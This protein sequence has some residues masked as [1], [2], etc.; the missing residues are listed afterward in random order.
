[1]AG[2]RGASGPRRGTPVYDLA[3]RAAICR[4]GAVGITRQNMALQGILKRMFRDAQRGPAAATDSSHRDGLIV[5]VEPRHVT[6][7]KTGGHSKVW[8]SGIEELGLQLSRYE[9]PTGIVGVLH[10]ACRTA[11]LRS[12]SL[13]SAVPHYVSLA[14]SP[15]AAKA[16]CTRLADLLGTP[17][18]MTELDEAESE[19][20]SQVSEA[21]ASDP[22]TQAYV[23]ELERRVMTDYRART[24]REPRMWV[25]R[26]VDGAGPLEA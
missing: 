13:W 2:M 15:R 6:T 14:P 21:V 3:R 25:V 8:F 24:G 23:E 7:I 1:M 22:D 4:Y 19:Y 20:S 9:G 17:I 11:G 12:V 26:A 5:G 16:L 18:D 10:D